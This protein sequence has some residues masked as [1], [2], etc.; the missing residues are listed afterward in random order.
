MPA[1]LKYNQFYTL[2]TK[3]RHHANFVVTGGTV[4]CHNEN[5]RCHQKLSIS[6]YAFGIDFYS[7]P[8]RY[9]KVLERVIGLRHAPWI[10]PHRP[11]W[12][13]SLRACILYV[14]E[15]PPRAPLVPRRLSTTPTRGLL[16]SPHPGEC[17][18]TQ[19]CVYHVLALPNA[20]PFVVS[21]LIYHLEELRRHHTTFILMIVRYVLGTEWYCYNDDSYLIC[22]ND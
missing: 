2:K 1:N 8:L 10:M 20:L 4:G 15:P 7:S 22:I 6:V 9:T 11:V 14:I 17:K 21:Y 3:S 19:T 5:I 18:A 12:S 13:T 16:Y